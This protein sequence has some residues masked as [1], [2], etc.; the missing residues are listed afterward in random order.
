MPIM[1]KAAAVVLIITFLAN[2]VLMSPTFVQRHEWNSLTSRAEPQFPDTPPSCPIC[3]QVSAGPFAPR[4]DTVSVLLAVFFLQNYD[5]ISS[6]AQAAPVLANISMV[7]F[8]PG[9]V[10]DVIKCACT[11][12]FQSVFPQ[13]VDCFVKT[14]QTDVLAT[15]DLP[16]LVG[17]IR[18]VCAIASTLLGNVSAADGEVNAT[19]SAPIASPTKT[20][21][22]DVD[23]HTGA[24]LGVIILLSLAMSTII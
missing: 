17:H 21:G 24:A 14:N 7:I 11:D 10:V 13:C 4:R 12:T 16:G 2:L 1:I 23:R 6:C 22:A 15:P 5:K 20:S 9:D 19:G 3:A 18:S 8:N